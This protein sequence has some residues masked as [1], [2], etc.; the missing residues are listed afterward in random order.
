MASRLIFNDTN[1]TLWHSCHRLAT[2]D[3]GYTQLANLQD[4]TEISL[5][6]NKPVVRATPVSSFSTTEGFSSLPTSL[7]GLLCSFLDYYFHAPYKAY[8]RTL[9]TQDLTQLR[10]ISIAA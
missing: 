4:R 5:C 2:T 9:K 1:S 6:E 7:R 3:L 10:C 8:A